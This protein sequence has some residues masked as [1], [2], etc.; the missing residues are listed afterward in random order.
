M[1]DLFFDD[2]V[3]TFVTSTSFSDRYDITEKKEY[4]KQRL[5]SKKDSIRKK[6][7]CFEERIVEL[8]KE[9]KKVEKDL[10]DIK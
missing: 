4:K 6:L 7:E 5:E 8:K 2:Y 10:E 9:L 3:Q 1:L